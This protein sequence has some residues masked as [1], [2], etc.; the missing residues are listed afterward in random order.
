MPVYTCPDCETKLKRSEPLPAGKK[1][2]ARSAARCSAPPAGESESRRPRKP[3]PPAKPKEE[4]K[5]VFGSSVRKAMPMHDDARE[6]A[7]FRPIKDRFERSDRGPALIHVV[8]PSDWLLRTGAWICVA[9]LHSA[10]CGRSGRW[11]SKSRIVQ[12]P[13]KSGKFRPG[14]HRAAPIQG[15]DATTS[16]R[17]ASSISAAFVGQFLWGAMVCVGASKMHTLES[18]PL[19]MI[20]SVMALVGPGVPAGIFILIESLKDNDA[21]LRSISILLITIPG[22]P[23]AMWCVATLRRRKSSTASPEEKPEEY[24]GDKAID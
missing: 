9:A 1:L 13:D 12:P 10:F 5:D 16:S 7:A 20:G 18:Y 17:C 6:D 2:A 11:S 4:P 22:V 19:A 21:V 3:A 14:R 24:V 23:M 8:R 15:T